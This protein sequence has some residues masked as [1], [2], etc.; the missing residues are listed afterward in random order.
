[1]RHDRQWVSGYI[2]LPTTYLNGERWEDE[3]ESPN[4]QHNGPL[5]KVLE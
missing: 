5:A 4:Q 3:I 1:V 2:P